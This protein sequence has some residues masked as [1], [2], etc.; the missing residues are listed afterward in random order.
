MIVGITAAFIWI[1]AGTIISFLPRHNHWRGA[2]ILMICFLPAF[3]LVGTTVG[4]G[5]ALLF[6][7]GAVSYLRYP[8][9]YMLKYLWCRAM[10]KN[11]EWPS[12]GRKGYGDD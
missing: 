7:G 4:W 10:G 12:F 8:T 5:W 1:V 9:Y 11:F 3:Y 2:I 6:F